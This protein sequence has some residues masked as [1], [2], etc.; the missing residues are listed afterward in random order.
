MGRLFQLAHI[1]AD[2]VPEF[3]CVIT[4]VFFYWM[5]GVDLPSVIL[6]VPGCKVDFVPRIR[7]MMGQYLL[8]KMSRSITY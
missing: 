1:P 7:T 5:I 3:A 6:L 2:L 8:A 4:W